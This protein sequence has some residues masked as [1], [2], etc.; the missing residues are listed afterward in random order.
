MLNLNTNKWKFPRIV[1]LKNNELRPTCEPKFP[2]MRPWKGGKPSSWS[3]KAKEKEFVT[4]FSCA[5]VQLER[6]LAEEKQKNLKLE[7]EANTRRLE[8]EIE[9]ELKEKRLRKD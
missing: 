2:T 3:K 8:M 5:R 9:M 4:K 7:Y 6:E 1:K